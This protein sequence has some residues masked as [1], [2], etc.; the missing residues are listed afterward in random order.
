MQIR[1]LDQSFELFPQKAA[2][3]I[4]EST[5]LVSDLHIG[6]V[7]HFRK[8]GIAVPAGSYSDNFRRLDE[9]MEACSPERVL[10]TGDL[11]HSDVNG[12]WSQFCE[13]RN[14]YDCD[15]EIVLGNHDRLPADFCSQYRI[16]MHQKEKKVGP[17]VFA[18]HPKPEGG[19]SGGYR[20]SGHIHPLVKLA[21]AGNQQ[22]RLPCFYFGKSQAI[23]PSFG[24]FTG[25]H[26]VIP[27]AG[28]RIVA[29]VNGTL[30]KV[31]G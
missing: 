12:E 28:D 27:R 16:S 18:H 26:A 5:L 17:F 22:V 29:I 2:L 4:E 7:S 15:M 3:W 30:R 23:L 19:Q 14:R 21:G 1:L 20:I 25:G 10:F 8:A 13:W 31:L 24:Y 9:L 11:F 6:K